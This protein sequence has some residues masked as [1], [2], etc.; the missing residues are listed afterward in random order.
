ML[1][2]VSFL[3]GCQVNTSKIK[4]SYRFENYILL[5][6]TS[7]K[8]TT[9]LT[10]WFSCTFCRSWLLKFCR[11]IRQIS[12]IYYFIIFKVVTRHL[13]RPWWMIGLERVSNSRR[14]SL[15]DPVSNPC[16]GLQYKYPVSYGNL[17]KYT[18]AANFASKNNLHLCKHLN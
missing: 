1:N 6:L 5:K 2:N 3:P 14:H 9:N 18:Y 16:S 17:V 11:S 4:V 8:S 15:K 10:N 7:T 12:G 13:N